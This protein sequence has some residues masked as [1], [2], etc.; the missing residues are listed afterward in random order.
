MSPQPTTP[1]KAPDAATAG[2]GAAGST[3]MGP[4]VAGLLSQADALKAE[5]D[6]LFVRIA[7][8]RDML[9]NLVKTGGAT[10][11]QK[12]AIDKLYP[13]RERKTKAKS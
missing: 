5:K 3:D 10:A 9:R 6:A 2:N 4:F 13:P 12:T 1:P 7:A 8:N 11:E